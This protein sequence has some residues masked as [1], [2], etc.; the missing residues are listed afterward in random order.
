MLYHPRLC[1]KIALVLFF[2]MLIVPSL[3]LAQTKAYG[4]KGSLDFIQYW[5][6]FQLFLHGKNPYDPEAMHALQLALGQNPEQTIMMWNPPWT[7]LVLAPAL[8]FP[9]ALSW[10]IWFL[11]SIGFLAGTTFLFHAQCGQKKNSLFHWVGISL[12]FYP[13]WECLIW[14]QLSLFLTFCFTLVLLG[15]MNGRDRTAGIFLALLSIKPHLFYLNA[16]FFIWWAVQQRRMTFLKSAAVSL[17]ALSGTCTLLAPHSILDWLQSLRG[18]AHP[19]VTPV[20]NWK[21]ASLVGFTRECLEI[22]TGSAPAWPMWVLPLMAL[23]CTVAY[24]LKRQRTSDSLSPAFPLLCL[25]LLTSPYG[26]LYDQSLLIVPILW[27]ASCS[28]VRFP[29]A[30]SRRKLFSILLFEIFLIAFAIFIAHGQQQFFWVPAV[31]LL[32]LAP[33]L[34][35]I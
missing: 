32:F 20:Q 24:L 10:K 3:S 13:A 8:I 22:I 1:V 35:Q 26:W 29:M 21:V 9:F 19:T 27:S 18:V 2:S 17:L 5:S 28:E 7:L 16:L 11:L 6:A 23:S 12:L 15:L 31:V 4:V 14:G 34:V 33:R 25:S 30:R